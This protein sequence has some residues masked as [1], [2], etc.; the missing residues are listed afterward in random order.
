MGVQILFVAK[1]N[2][3]VLSK[4]ALTLTK[5]TQQNLLCKLLDWEKQK[6]LHVNK[7]VQGT[8]EMFNETPK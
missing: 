4:F 6:F 2:I 8:D 5:L 3:S 1:Q 7:S